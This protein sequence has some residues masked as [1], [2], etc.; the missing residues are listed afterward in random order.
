MI[1]G[2]VVEFFKHPS[3][4][5][6]IT[7]GIVLIGG[8]CEVVI[9]FPFPGACTLLWL[10]AVFWRPMGA[11]LEQDSGPLATETI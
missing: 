9:F 8:L 11:S 3:I 2:Q 6:D 10:T 1:A 4:L 7:L 5:P